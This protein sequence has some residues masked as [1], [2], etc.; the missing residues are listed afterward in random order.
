[1]IDRKPDRNLALELVRV[2]EAAAMAA[3]RW[4]GRG[5]KESADQA[6]VDAM[7][8]MLDTVQMDGVVVIG[9]G[10]KDEAPMLYNGEEVGS[11]EGPQV[12]VAVDPLEGLGAAGP[13]EYPIPALPL[14]EETFPCSSCHADQAPDPNRRELGFHEDI[15]L[16]HDEENRWCLDCHENPQRFVRPS[17][18]VFDMEWEAEDQ[19]AVGREVVRDLGLAP[20]TTCTGC[21]R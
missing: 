5:E 14:N 3:G 20:T 21:H 8:L 4:I 15:V 13:G 2:T 7:R 10:E 18:A 19:D 1:M 12:D 9:E 16:A 17:E 11:G 6:A